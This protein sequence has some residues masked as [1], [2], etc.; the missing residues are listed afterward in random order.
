MWSNFKNVRKKGGVQIRLKHLKP[1]AS[2]S[3]ATLVYLCVEFSSLVNV[4]Q[5]YII[6]MLLSL[7][8]IWC[9][10]G[11]HGAKDVVSPPINISNNVGATTG[12]NLATCSE[13]KSHMLSSSTV[14]GPVYYPSKKSH[15][16]AN[17]AEINNNNDHE[18]NVQHSIHWNNIDQTTN[19]AGLHQ[20]LLTSQTVT[21]RD[22][23]C[24]R[25]H[26]G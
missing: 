19:V 8:Y 25:P 24:P 9:I 1:E 22:K 23:H 18:T 20:L 15:L 3:T 11:I 2:A 10:H 16:Y 14:L 6:R 7:T 5:N 21:I 17:H 13:Q 4:I 12:V 26:L